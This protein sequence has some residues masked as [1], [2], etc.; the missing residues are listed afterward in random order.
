MR[1]KTVDIVLIVL[2]LAAMFTATYTLRDAVAEAI[3]KH[4]FE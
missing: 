1:E 3:I 2:V 4:I